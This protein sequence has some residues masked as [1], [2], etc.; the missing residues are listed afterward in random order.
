MSAL[1]PRLRHR[2]TFEEFVSERD[3]EGVLNESWQTATSDDGDALLEVPAE[4]LTGPGR[5]MVAGGAVQADVAARITLRWFPG[6]KSS[7][8]ILWDGRVFNIGGEPDTDA[9]ARREW[10]IKASA[11]VN[12]G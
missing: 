7:W 6:L 2:I 10:R 1:T 5:E 8:R 11:G 12:D 9:T 4:V 3:S